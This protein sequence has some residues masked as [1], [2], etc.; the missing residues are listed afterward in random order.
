MAIA[1]SLGMRT[2]RGLWILGLLAGAWCSG[3]GATGNDG[4]GDDSCEAN[5]VIVAS[6]QPAA[7]TARIAI[8]GAHAYWTYGIMIFDAV[9]AA[10]GTVT[11]APV[12]GGALTAVVSGQR[13][14]TAIALGTSDVFWIDEFGTGDVMKAPKTGGEPTR[15]ATFNPDGNAFELE[16]DD[17]SVY[18]L[19]YDDG[20]PGV[21]KAPVGG[22]DAIRLATGEG[23][24]EELALDD[25]HVYWAD[26]VP[27]TGQNRIM[28]V[29]IEGGEPA[30][31]S[32]LYAGDLAVGPS[33]VYFIGSDDTAGTRVLQ[34]PL[35]GGAAVAV[36]EAADLRRV[37]VNSKYVYWTEQGDRSTSIRK[38]PLNGGQS[39]TV[40]SDQVG[41]SAFAVD[42]ASVCWLNFGNGAIGE[43]ACRDACGG[44]S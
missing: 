38:A 11:R 27:E 9:P 44:G 25:T 31:L 2:L 26:Q 12:A 28:K 23:K 33:G 13:V 43:V 19:A 6:E 3:C 37:A 22:G 5:A 18:W 42:D 39:S 10:T 32:E 21:F 36:S 24:L 1:T 7:V 35:A 30:V 14:P 4:A 40:V 8:D 20:G 34:I 41:L 29:S 15:I 17:E 16:V